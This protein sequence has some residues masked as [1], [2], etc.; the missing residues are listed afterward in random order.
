VVSALDVSVQ[1]QILNLLK[2]LQQTFR[3][4]ML[5]I[6]HALPVL[7][8]ISDEIAVMYLGKIVEWSSSSQLFEDPLHP[9]TQGLLD[10]VLIPDPALSKSLRTPALNGEV[11]TAARLP[12]GCVF[13]ERCPHAFGKCREQRPAL[14]ENRRGHHVACYLY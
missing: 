6:S 5:F 10:S 9:Y 7:K 3:L 12:R 8:Y 1:A 13:S 14:E 2:D 11:P 4:S